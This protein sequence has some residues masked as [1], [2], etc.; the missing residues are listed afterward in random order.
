[1]SDMEIEAKIDR[2]SFSISTG[3]SEMEAVD[4]WKKQNFAERL[5]AVELMR[6][7]NYGHSSASRLQRVFEIVELKKS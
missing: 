1:M 3:F 4:Y 5:K 6:K 2:S 7:L